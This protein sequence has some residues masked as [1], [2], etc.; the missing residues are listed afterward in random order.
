MQ[1][2][3][4]LMIPLLT[5]VRVTT[6]GKLYTP[7]KT[8]LDIEARDFTNILPYA[9][10][11]VLYSGGEQVGNLTWG[12]FF[13]SSVLQTFDVPTLNQIGADVTTGTSTRHTAFTTITKFMP[14]ARLLLGIGNTSGAAPEGGILTAMLG[15][16]TVGL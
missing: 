16:K 6:S 3:R 12:I 14:N 5:R 13:Y 10:E 9:E 4:I 11:L 7:D 15:V 8:L 2:Y 1:R